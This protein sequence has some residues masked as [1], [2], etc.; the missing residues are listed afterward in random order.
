MC[1]T[2]DRCQLKLISTYLT[3]QERWKCTGSACIKQR[4]VICRIS[5][6]TW[7]KL[8]FLQNGLVLAS[9]FCRLGKLTVNFV[10][11]ESARVV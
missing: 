9:A 1:S 3:Q 11:C 5:S 8:H 10:F 4:C 6:F 7:Q 2:V